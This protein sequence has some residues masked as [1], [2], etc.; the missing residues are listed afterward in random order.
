M[1]S[2]RHRPSAQHFFGLSGVLGVLRD[3]VGRL[4][5]GIALIVASVSANDAHAQEPLVAIPTPPPVS[6]RSLA[7][8]ESINA[9]DVMARLLLLQ[10]NLERVRR[11]M[12]R[13][14]PLPPVIRVA[15]A[16]TTEVYFNSLN[17]LR[18]VM[19]LSFEQLR[20][21]Q[22]W[23]GELPEVV[24]PFDVYVNLDRILGRVLQIKAALGIDTAV[25]EVVQPATTTMTEVFNAIIETGALV[26]ILLDHM[27]NNEETFRLLT[28][29]V[30]A[31]MPLHQAHTRKMM[32]EAP[33]FEPNKL[34]EQVFVELETC[35][36][37]T[38][39]IANRLGVDVLSLQEVEGRRDASPDDVSELTVLLIAEIDRLLLASDLPRAPRRNLSFGRKFPSHGLQ[40]AR[41]LRA[42]LE[43]L[44]AAEV[45]A[46]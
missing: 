30:H 11:F 32:P 44:V 6:G 16:T 17:L 12:G 33:V 41:L 28:L 18:R 27:T 3:G 4:G 35:F 46:R 15:H 37:L 2:I 13:Y 45:P 21:E 29:A 34:P 42:I 22:Q 7:Q 10:R 1:A 14:P 40:R 39:Q 20:V 25:A 24:R 43:D 5:V 23:D 8:P 26:N 36:T 19:R 9:A 38:A 31:T